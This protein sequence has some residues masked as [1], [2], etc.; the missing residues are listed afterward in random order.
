MP[1]NFLPILNLQYQDLDRL[2]QPYRALID[3]P[4]VVQ[5]YRLMSTLTWL[6]NYSKCSVLIFRAHLKSP[7]AICWFSRFLCKGMISGKSTLQ[8]FLFLCN[9]IH[10]FL[11]NKIEYTLK[12]I[13]LLLNVPTFRIWAKYYM[14]EAE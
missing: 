13:I 5:C 8:R 7:A 14:R 3:S 12:I 10:L 11:T 4:R 6:F 1:V 9:T 2:Q